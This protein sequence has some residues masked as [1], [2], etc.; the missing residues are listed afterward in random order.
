LSVS[1][2]QL[3]YQGLVADAAFVAL[4]GADAGGNPAFYD[5]QL[6][7]QTFATFASNANYTAG[8]YQRISS[9]RLFAHGAGSGQGNTGVARFQLTFWSN[10]AEGTVLLDSLDLALKSFFQSFSA[11]GSPASTNPGFFAYTSRTEIEAEMQP[12]L[13]KLVIQVQFWFSDQ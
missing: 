4:L 10:S 1:L 13:Q 7:Q 11:W 5:K 9:P 6:P 12:T 8:V 2:E 3:V